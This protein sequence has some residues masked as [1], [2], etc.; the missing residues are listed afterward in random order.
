MCRTHLR[1]FSLDWADY[2][3]SIGGMWSGARMQYLLKQN[4]GNTAK[5]IARLFEEAKKLYDPPLTCDPDCK[6]L[7]SY[8][9]YGSS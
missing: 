4:A 6:S 9:I 5:L 2:E 3:E 1:H 8:V 7:L